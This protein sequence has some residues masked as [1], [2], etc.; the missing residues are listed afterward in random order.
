MESLVWVWLRTFTFFWPSFLVLSLLCTVMAQKWPCSVNAQDTTTRLNCPRT[1]YYGGTRNWEHEK[2]KSSSETRWW[3]RVEGT[4]AEADSL[5]PCSQLSP[6]DS[7]ASTLL[8]N[9]LVS[10]QRRRLECSAAHIWPLWRCW[11]SS[12]S[13]KEKQMKEKWQIEEG[14]RDRGGDWK[15]RQRPIHREI[16]VKG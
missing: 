4:G 13:L 15:G 2:L 6:E 5:R 11:H 12:N 16:Q 7:R 8:P 14:G 9:L 10:T 3:L 1:W